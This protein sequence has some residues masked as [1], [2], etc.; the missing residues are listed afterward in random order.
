MLKKTSL[1]L[2]LGV[3]IMQISIP[4][5]ADNSIRIGETHNFVSSVLNEKR[6]IQ[7]YLPATYGKYPKQ[8]YPVIYLLDSE[9]NFHYLTGIVEKLSK[10]PYPSIPE[11]VVVGIVNTERARDLTPTK[12][13]P[14][15]K[16]GRV[17]EGE[18]GGNVAF[19]KF[20]ESELMPDIEKKYRTNGLNILIGH[21]FGGI[22]ALNHMLNGQQNI[23]AY[24]V[25]DP[26][27]WWDDEI[28]LKRFKEANNQDFQHKTLFLTQVGASENTDSLDNHYKGIKKFNQ[29]L[30]QQP[31]TQLNYKYV[32]YEGE[33]HGTVPIKGNLDGLRYIFE[34]MRVNIKAIPENPNLIKQ[35]YAQLSQNLGFEIQPSEAYLDR[36]L[37]YLK[38]SNNPKVIQQ[39]QDYI[40]SIYPQWRVKTSS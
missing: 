12:Q 17:I 40:L 3:L 39:F 29:Y 5:F 28:M 38:R 21:S 27:I 6:P 36:V 11:M 26:S 25:H 37:D 1:Y 19:F 24:I 16:Q 10:S 14:E 30:S 15:I 31:F 35:H 20:L 18:T 4:T 22:T 23:Q 13:K 7:I 34:G 2:A 9:T 32:Q 8:K 33:D